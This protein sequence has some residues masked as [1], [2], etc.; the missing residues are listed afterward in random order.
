[1]LDLLIGDRDA[2]QMRDAADGGG[3]DGHG[4]SGSVAAPVCRRAGLAE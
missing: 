2:R 3:V 4:T 1:V